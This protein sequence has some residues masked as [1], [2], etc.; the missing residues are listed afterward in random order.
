MGQA[1][2]RLVADS[3]PNTSTGVRRTVGFADLV[4]YT[5]LVRSMSER[6]LAR[7]VSRFERMASDIIS[8]HAGALVK[9]VGDE[10]LFTH[11]RASA[12]ARIALDLADAA[13]ADDLVPRMRVGLATGKVLARLGDVFG[14]TVD[15]AAR[16][17]T[18]AQAGHI[19]VD[20]STA[21]LLEHRSEF[22]LTKW[23][24]VDLSGIGHVVPYDLQRADMSSSGDL[25]T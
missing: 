23:S 7:L 17:T 14:H 13:L 15:Q 11:P 21:R 6:D 10:V 9:T 20:D 3:Q 1:V 8:S 25:A 5:G 24:V 19:L 16:L 18:V 2:T 4:S 12:A 22:E